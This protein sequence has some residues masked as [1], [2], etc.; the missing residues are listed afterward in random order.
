[1]ALYR[2]TQAALLQMNRALTAAK[3][4][5]TDARGL[6]RITCAR[7]FGRKFIAP[8]AI[9]F[10][11]SYPEIDI[12]LSLDDDVIDLIEHGAD[13]AIRGGHREDSR[14]I[15]RSL[16]IMPFYVCAT[17]KYLA[18]EGTPIQSADIAHH[19]CVAFKVGVSSEPMRWEFD[20]SGKLYRMEVRGSFSV[21]DIESA[22]QAALA[23]EGLV[24]LPGYLAVEHIRAGRLRPV[25]LDQLSRHRSF[26]I[27]YVNRRELQP[28]RDTL[29]AD[30]IYQSLRDEKL[31]SLTA[32]EL[33]N[34]IV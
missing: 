12:D 20:D 10:R 22:C 17:P 21:N 28:L 1:M 2:D 4:S 3:Q 13:M 8:L 26:S 27:T 33:Q 7:N 18:R 34:F 19:K 6:L 24:Q 31:F 25:L 14:L 23:D 32:Q 30:Y 15:Y 9:S 5:R 16:A 11:K 29:F